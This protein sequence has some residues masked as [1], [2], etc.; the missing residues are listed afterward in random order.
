MATL[1]PDTCQVST[2]FSVTVVFIFVLK[3]LLF[4]RNIVKTTW[5]ACL[6]FERFLSTFAE[7]R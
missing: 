6:A 2:L 5:D 3:F 1:V 7:Q 4:K